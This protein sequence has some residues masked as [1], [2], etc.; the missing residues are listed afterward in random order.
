MKKICCNCH[1]VFEVKQYDTICPECG[2]ILAFDTQMTSG[3]PQGG[4]LQMDNRIHKGDTIGEIHNGN[5][6]HVEGDS[7]QS[8][9]KSTTVNNTTTNNNTTNIYQQVDKGRE[10]VV[11]EYS[12]AN[13]YLSDTFKC[14]RCHRIIHN[15][16]YVE[17][18]ICCKECNDKIEAAQREVL[19]TTRATPT[20]NN[21]QLYASPDANVQIQ[22]PK[23]V[24]SSIDVRP[25]ISNIPYNDP[26]RMGNEARPNRKYMYALAILLVAGFIWYLGSRNKNEASKNTTEQTEQQSVLDET[27]S[28]VINNT[29]LATSKTYKSNAQTVP[30]ASASSQTAKS[31]TET[32]IDAPTVSSMEEGEAAYNSGNYTKAKIFLQ[33]ASEEGKAAANY[34]LALMYKEG[35][36]VSVDIQK[37]FTYM[38]KAAEGGEKRACFP[39]AEMYRNGDGTEANRAQAKKWYEQTIVSDPNH[40]QEASEI[41]DIYE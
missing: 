7:A 25:D 26:S 1:S 9:D 29:T 11:C 6:M 37:S 34:Y 14:N 15:R 35:K 21:K 24:N 33:Q 36:G 20:N 28:E 19:K 39:L 8:I 12:G 2:G 23:A 40:A 4:N 22:P 30:S 38:R 13:V 27:S 18:N 17:K 41:L 32:V 3:V 31:E 16:F 5:E 10:M